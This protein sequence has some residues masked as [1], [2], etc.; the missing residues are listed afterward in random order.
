ML[1]GRQAFDGTSWFEARR[2]TEEKDAII[3]GEI[4][5]SEAPAIATSTSPDRTSRKASPIAEVPEAHA[6]IVVE[7]EP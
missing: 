5:A 4:G 2:P 6:V 7:I 3:I 1:K